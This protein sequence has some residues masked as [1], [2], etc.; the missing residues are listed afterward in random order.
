MPNDH[1]ENS[2]KSV[3]APLKALSACLA[4]RDMTP[5]YPRI[6]ER[7]KYAPIAAELPDVSFF[8]R[9]FGDKRQRAALRPLYDAVVK[10]GRDPVWYRDGGV[11]DTMEGRFDLLSAL[12]AIVLLRLESEGE[13]ARHESVML[14]ELYVDDMDGTLRQLGIGDVV[15]G[16]HV[17]KMMGMLGGQLGALRTAFAAGSGDSGGGA[18][19]LVPAVRRN[20]FREAPPSEEAVEWV[21]SRLA[22]LQA[23]LGAKPL[24]SLLAGEIQ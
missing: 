3:R 13:G 6:A 5:Q 4:G 22:D 20:I 24:P 1:L 9:L 16:K 2:P 19:A 17:G 8:T 14:T 23:R 10:A 7:R 21:A 18:G 15:V 11:P 12:V